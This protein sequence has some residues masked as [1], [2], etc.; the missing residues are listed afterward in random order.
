MKAR[1]LSEVPGGRRGGEQ[2]VVPLQV[3]VLSIWESRE[4][5][6]DSGA[7]EAVGLVVEQQG[8]R[9]G[10]L[11]VYEEH[12]TALF[13]AHLHFDLHPFKFPGNHAAPQSV[14]LAKNRSFE[15]RIRY[16]DR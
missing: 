7:G 5:E 16:N 13:S 15:K 8:T 9:L 3:G 2:L 11:R 14:Q 4:M 1:V 12:N 10:S 6:Q